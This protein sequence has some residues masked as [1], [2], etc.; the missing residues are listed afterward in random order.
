[1]HSV[2][3]ENYEKSING[4]DALAQ[5]MIMAMI[6]AHARENFARGQ[7]EINDR[8]MKKDNANAA[9]FVYRAS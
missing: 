2:G 8:N 4:T 9:P 3:F 6:P 7:K 1:M 5:Q